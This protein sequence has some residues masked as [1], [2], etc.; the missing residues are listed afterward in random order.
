MTG[1]ED[2]VP[3]VGWFQLPVFQG[4]EPIQT[5]LPPALSPASVCL[6]HSATPC[7]CNPSHGTPTPLGSALPIRVPRT[8]PGS[9]TPTGDHHTLPTPSLLL[10]STQLDPHQPRQVQDPQ[11]SP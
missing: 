7:S 1:E 9:V 6:H 3:A 8:M 5:E 2:G 10:S 4:E 11:G